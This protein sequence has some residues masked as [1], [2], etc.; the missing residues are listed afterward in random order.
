M[1]SKFDRVDKAL[2][3]HQYNIEHHPENM[4]S[5]WSQV[6]F[7]YYHIRDGNEA[8]ADAAFDELVSAYAHQPGLAREVYQIALE[9][10]EAKEYDK[11]G[12]RYRGTHWESPESAVP[13]GKDNSGSR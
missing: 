4:Y 11:A 7:V 9:Y 13:R 8:G 1:Y 5:M 2:E 12:R 3:I 10:A 6:E